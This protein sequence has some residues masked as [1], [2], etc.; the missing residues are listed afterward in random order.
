VQGEL[1]VLGRVG[2]ANHIRPPLARSATAR[3]RTFRAQNRHFD[4]SDA[5]R[6]ARQA[7]VCP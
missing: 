7:L 4:Q 2:T 3:A 5:A 6:S 1:V